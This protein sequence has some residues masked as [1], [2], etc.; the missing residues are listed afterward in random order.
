MTNIVL[1]PGE[2]HVVIAMLRTIGCFIDNSG[3]EAAWL[4]ADLYGQT[5]IK[6]IIDD[7][8]VKRGVKAYTVTLLSLFAMN[9]EAFSKH[10]E[11]SSRNA[12]LSSLL[13]TRIVVTCHLMVL[14]FQVPEFALYNQL[15]YSSPS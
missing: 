8:H 13:S 9:V 2:L 5:T 4:N 14:L 15:S 10:N 11:S 7:N 1:R 3:I 6:Q 12:C